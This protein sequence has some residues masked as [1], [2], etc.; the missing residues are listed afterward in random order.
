MN[1]TDP[2][3]HA[4]LSIARTSVANQLEPRPTRQIASKKPHGMKKS[5]VAV[6]ICP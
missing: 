4:A 5:D 2:L 6:H 3:K 1:S